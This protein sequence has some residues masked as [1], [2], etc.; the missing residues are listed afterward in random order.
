MSVDRP[1]VRSVV[2]S[3]VRTI[4]RTFASFIADLF[5]TTIQKGIGSVTPPVIGDTDRNRGVFDHE[6][7][8]HFV[9]EE[10]VRQWG[11]RG[12]EN[13]IAFSEDMTNGAYGKEAGATFDSAEK[14]TFD[15]TDGTDIFHNVTIVDN[16][17]GSGSRTFIYSAKVRLESGTISGDSAVAIRLGGTAMND[18]Q[19]NIGSSITT[20]AKRF[21]VNATTD[22]AG[23]VVGPG[24]QV[25]DAITLEITEWQ[26]EES[27]GRADTTTPSEY[28][29]TGVGT[30]SELV[31]NGTN[32]TDTSG[33][34][35]ARAASTLSPVGGRLRITADTGGVTF[36][37]SFQIDNLLVGATYL[38][39]F[40]IFEG[41]ATASTM[42]LR[43]DSSSGLDSDAGEVQAFA[44]L[45][46]SLVFKA[47][48]T[49][50][51]VGTIVTGHSTGEYVELDNISVKQIDHNANVDG[52]KYFT[53]LNGN[54]VS[55]N[56]VTELTGTVIPA[57]I[58]K[59]LF[60]E[61]AA[62][63][64][65]G[66]S[67]DIGNW[68]G[69]PTA[70]ILRNAVG[71]TGALNEAETSTDSS[72]SVRQKSED[73]TNISN[74]SNLYFMKTTVAFD[75]SPSVF[76][77]ILIRL[78]GGSTP[79][80]QGLV[81]DPSD[82]SY[83]ETDTDGSVVSVLRIGNFWEVI[84]LAT[85]NSTGN[86]VARMGLS[87]AFNTDGTATEAVSAQGSTVFASCEIYK[88]VFSFSPILTTG[89][90]TKTRLADT[91]ITE[92]VL[93]IPG[94]THSMEIELTIHFFNVTLAS[95]E[96]II[97]LGSS[98]GLRFGTTANSLELFDGTNTVTLLNAWSSVEETVPLIYYMSAALTEMNLSSKGVKATKGTY[99]PFAPSQIKLSNI[100]LGIS[101][102]NQK[103][104][105]FSV[106]ES[107][108]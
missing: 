105:Q 98:K 99:D 83:A 56:I 50:M 9:L 6:D 1:V 2:R 70:Q 59:G 91:K 16:G 108:I 7:I 107:G 46:G 94:K 37:A 88:D 57:S 31:T 13:L 51:Y 71:L 11:L 90:V 26:L 79:V 49:T 84:Q 43:F 36:G 95:P 100:S 48:A 68:A 18:T 53:T 80:K 55:N 3:V 28:I 78:L 42:R 20:T 60:A 44:D 96:L 32:I 61:G 4:I 87:P 10:Q 39:S 64:L 45:V 85:D 106:G 14:V 82:G 92:N 22:A 52:V 86:N 40:N 34:G 35:E 97:D 74:G 58:L 65:S 38:Y 69:N 102:K 8:L 62:T 103:I 12:V 81:L 47:T 67:A 77:L 66:K 33:W 24:F 21:T 89:G 15:G 29:S 73:D 19:V 54:T 30:G 41:T 25:D 23:T 75:S 93:N 101:L 27:T 72:G 17:G 104:R 63:E 5:S 76:P